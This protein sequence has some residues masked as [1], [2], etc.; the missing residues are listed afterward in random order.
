MVFL[1]VASTILDDTEYHEDDG[2]GYNSFQSWHS[3]DFYQNSEYQEN[4]DVHDINCEFIRPVFLLRHLW[5]LVCD[6]STLN[7]LNC[8]KYNKGFCM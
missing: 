8:M 4:E 7:R 2:R 6:I 3:D 5:L 1:T